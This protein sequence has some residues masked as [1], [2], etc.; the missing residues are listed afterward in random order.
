MILCD[1]HIDKAIQNGN[2]IIDPPPESGQLQSSSLDLRVGD[3]FRTG[4]E[5][6]DGEDA[7]RMR[8]QRHAHARRKQ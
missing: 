5:R 7:S 6:S 8:G 4:R 3:D 1:H 2:L